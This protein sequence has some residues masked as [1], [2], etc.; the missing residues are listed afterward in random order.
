M[1]HHQALNS[2]A[3]RFIKPISKLSLT[4]EQVL[5][6][7][8]QTTIT[9]QSV[10]VKEVGASDSGKEDTPDGW[11]TYQN[12]TLNFSIKYPQNLSTVAENVKTG[13]IVFPFGNNCH[14][15]ICEGVYISVVDVP[16][17]YPPKDS[18]AIDSKV[19]KRICLADH[20]RGTSCRPRQ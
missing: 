20:F 10:D 2:L 5:P 7:S 9:R 1:W 11:V 18:Q 14:Q 19:K 4:P 17:D 13:Q 12:S 15:T 16:K 8:E 6:I 3:S